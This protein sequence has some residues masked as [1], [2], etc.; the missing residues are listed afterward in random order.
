MTLTL[1]RGDLDTGQKESQSV[2]VIARPLSLL[3][4]KEERRVLDGESEK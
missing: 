1:W 3:Q 4:R 2:N